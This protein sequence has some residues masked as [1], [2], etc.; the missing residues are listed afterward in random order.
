[1]AVANTRLAIWTGTP[2]NQT[3]SEKS[4][5]VFTP[6]QPSLGAG[7]AAVD[8]PQYTSFSDGY[9]VNTTGR[10]GPSVSSDQ[11]KLTK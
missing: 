9:Q 6:G 10:N 4:F 8:C 1:M 7:T 11:G 2:P 5:V 3:P